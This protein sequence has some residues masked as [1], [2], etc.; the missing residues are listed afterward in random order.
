MTN[1]AGGCQKV[2]SFSSLQDDFIIIHEEEY[3][4]VLQSVFKT[5]FLSLLVKRYQDKAKKKLPLKFNNLSVAAASGALTLQE[6]PLSLCLHVSPVLQ[7]GV[8]GEEGRLGPVHLR[9]LQADSVPAG[10]RR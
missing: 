8:Q 6:P 2:S 9:R 4:S 5:E 7:S 1:E 3:D 10:S